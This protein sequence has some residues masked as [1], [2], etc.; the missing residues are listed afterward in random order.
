V[1]RLRVRVIPRAKRDELAGE[2]DGAV[3]VRV[4]APPAEGRANAAVCALV[5]RRAGVPKSRVTVVRGASRR[6]KVLEVEGIGEA[7]LRRALAR[8]S[9]T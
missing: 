2:R 1:T 8:R 5:A 4:T 9:A 3:V 6:D 7:E